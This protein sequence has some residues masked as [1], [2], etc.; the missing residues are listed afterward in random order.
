MID[1]SKTTMT[2]QSQI[3]DLFLESVFDED[4]TQKHG[5]SV[6]VD[7]KNFS[8]TLLKWLTPSNVIIAVKKVDVSDVNNC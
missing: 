8:W 6:V 4:K 5:L 7:L 2:K 3:Q 1:T